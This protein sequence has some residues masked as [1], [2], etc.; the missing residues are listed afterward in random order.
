[1][2]APTLRVPSLG[3]AVQSSTLLV[4]LRTERVPSFDAAIFAATV[5]AAAAAGQV[6]R[7][8]D[9]EHPDRVQRHLERAGGLGQAPP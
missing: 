4:L 6:G 1:M 2:T 5:Q 7:S 9:A 3:A 8:A